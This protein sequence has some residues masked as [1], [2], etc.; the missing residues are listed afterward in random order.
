[1]K[2]TVAREVNA[3]LFR[4][5]LVLIPLFGVPEEQ[6]K[7]KTLFCQLFNVFECDFSKAFTM[8]ALRKLLDNQL[9]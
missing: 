3:N 9:T 6:Q 5:H 8:E 7:W 1:M 4:E 2:K